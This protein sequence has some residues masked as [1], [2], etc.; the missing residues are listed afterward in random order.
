MYYYSGGAFLCF[1]FFIIIVSCLI[2]FLIPAEPQAPLTETVVV[3]PRPV[4][5]VCVPKAPTPPT[6][7]V[8]AMKIKDAEGKVLT[9]IEFVPAAQSS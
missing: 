1:I 5:H 7:L 4:E 3:R 9:T 8:Q 6:A 2:V